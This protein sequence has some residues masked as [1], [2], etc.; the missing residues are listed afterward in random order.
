MILYLEAV[1]YKVVTALETLE[2]H[3]PTVS[4][5]FAQHIETTR[6]KNGHQMSVLK[7]RALDRSARRV[8]LL[9]FD[10]FPLCSPIRCSHRSSLVL[11]MPASVCQKLMTTPSAV[12]A[13]AAHESM[14]S[15]RG[16]ADGTDIGTRFAAYCRAGPADESSSS[17]SSSSSRT[18]DDRKT[19][20]PARWHRLRVI[21]VGHCCSVADGVRVSKAYRRVLRDNARRRSIKI[22]I[23]VHMVVTLWYCVPVRRKIMFR[24]FPLPPQCHMKT[25]IL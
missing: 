1:N 22:Y 3:P 20:G 11:Q 19:V 23:Y 14:W 17:S 9:I 24:R 12:T 25:D 2:G 16:S 21:A 4:N 10:Y 18:S 7:V 15:D 8:T 5:T 6:D 13:V